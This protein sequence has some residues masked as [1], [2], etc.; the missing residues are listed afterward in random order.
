MWPGDTPSPL[1][2]AITTYF[3]WH[4]IHVLSI[5]SNARLHLKVFFIN[6]FFAEHYFYFKLIS[7]T[8]RLILCSKYLKIVTNKKWRRLCCHRHE[9]QLIPHLRASEF[10][11]FVLKK[12]IAITYILCHNVLQWPNCVSSTPMY[13]ERLV[14]QHQVRELT[15]CGITCQYLQDNDLESQFSVSLCLDCT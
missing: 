3:N 5:P 1:S 8:G 13:A 12:R 6:I 2:A 14:W 4:G 9:T 10:W 15:K 11:H 7:Q